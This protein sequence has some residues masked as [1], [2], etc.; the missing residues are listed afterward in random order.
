M[1]HWGIKSY[2]NDDA[3]DALDAGFERVH[4]DR[5]EELMDDR[6]PLSYDQVQQQLATAE[7]LA[8][9]VE[10]LIERV[11]APFDDWDEIDRLAFAGIIVRHAELGV[12]IPGDHRA[13]ALDWLERETIDW[14]DATLRK[15]RRDKE[16][17]LLQSAG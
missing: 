3:A 17:R 13:R 9:A 16:I 1:G 11:D 5:Y 15:L 8:A 7:T 12:P 4:G 6:C 2:E 14:D 10:A